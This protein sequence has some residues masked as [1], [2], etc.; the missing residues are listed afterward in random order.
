MAWQRQLLQVNLTTL[1]C[2]S[3][4]LNNDTKTVMQGSDDRKSLTKDDT[5]PTSILTEPATCDSAKGLVCRL[6]EMLPE[7][8]K[9]RGWDESGVPLAKT[10]KRLGLPR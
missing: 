6:D 8:Y 2:A 4:P 9:L 7:Y 5:L 3:E 10:L 1:N